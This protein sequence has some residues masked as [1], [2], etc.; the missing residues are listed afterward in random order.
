MQIH[1]FVRQPVRLFGEIMERRVRDYE[2]ARQGRITVLWEPEASD[3]GK[4]LTTMIAAGNPPAVTDLNLD[5]FPNWAAQGVL[6]S[7][8]SFVKQ[9][10][11]FSLRDFYPRLI[12]ARRWRGALG[13]I[14]HYAAP[15]PLYYNRNLFQAKGVVLPH[16]EWSWKDLRA[17]A[18]KLTSPGEG[19]WGFEANSSVTWWIGHYWS[20]GAEL[21]SKD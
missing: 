9:D 2:A 12:D 3:F 1:A 13:R 8:E 5:Q 11:A 16:K 4:K 6:L 21:L 15:Y 7:L 14:P 10:R 17:A 20:E 19:I 18:L